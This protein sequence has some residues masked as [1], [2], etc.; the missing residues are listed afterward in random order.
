[1]GI[2]RSR[3]ES[4]T[5]GD[6]TRESIRVPARETVFRPFPVVSPSDPLYTE[7]MFVPRRYIS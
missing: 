3:T 1:M 6:D 2:R 4:D 5:S 7:K